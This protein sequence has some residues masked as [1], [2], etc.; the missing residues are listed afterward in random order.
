MRQKNEKVREETLVEIT[1][2]EQNKEKGIKRNE[3]V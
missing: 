2:M 1:D 3:A